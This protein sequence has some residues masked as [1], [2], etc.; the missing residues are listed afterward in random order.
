MKRRRISSSLS[1]CSAEI[2][3][4]VAVDELIEDIRPQHGRRRNECADTLEVMSQP[5]Y[6]DEE[7]TERQAARLAPERSATD[8]MEVVRRVEALAIEIR[9]LSERPLDAVAGDG[10]KDTLAQLV[11]AS[12]IAE[13][14]RAQLLRETEL[15][16]RLEPA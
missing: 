6:P 5:P 1:H 11:D 13:P 16:P 8:P 9:D 12:K 10:M 7:S 3:Q 14:F 15:R 4:P 2:P